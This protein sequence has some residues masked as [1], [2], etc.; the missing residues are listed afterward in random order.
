M[1]REAELDLQGV[2]VPVIY[3]ITNGEVN[4]VKAKFKDGVTYDVS[5]LLIFPSIRMALEDH[6][7]NEML[8]DVHV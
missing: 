5:V 7:A 8:N 4:F 2:C 6:H 1:I 3:S